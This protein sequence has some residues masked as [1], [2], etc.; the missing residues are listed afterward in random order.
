MN[1][2]RKVAVAAGVAAASTVSLVIATPAE[3]ATVSFQGCTVTNDAPYYAGFDNASNVP[4]VYYP[5]EVTCSA[6]LEIEVEMVR[7]EQD[8]AWREGPGYEDEDYLSTSTYNWDFTGGAG[9]VSYRSQRTLPLTNN[10]GIDEEIY[11]QVRFRVT[12]GTVTG[13]WTSHA[14]SPVSAIRH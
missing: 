13:P 4:Y 3:G 2:I 9:T 7:W 12:S 14:F 8:L 11:D 6:G 1:R 10:E 5:L